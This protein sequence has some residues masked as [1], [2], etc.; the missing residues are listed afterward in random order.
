MGHPDGS[1][2]GDPDQEVVAGLGQ[3]ELGAAVFAGVCGFDVAAEDLCGDLHAVADA[4]DGNA[5]LEDARVAARGIGFI[6]GGRAAGEDDPDGIQ[7]AQFIQRDIR[8]ALSRE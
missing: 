5:E 7:L 1:I 3:V 6:H 2:F 8:G 4:Q